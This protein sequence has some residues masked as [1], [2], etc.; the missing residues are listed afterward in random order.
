MDEKEEQARKVVKSIKVLEGVLKTSPNPTQRA[1][2]KREID[3]LRKMLQEMY[4]DEN[5]EEIEES[6]YDEMTADDDIDENS[7]AGYEYLKDVEI[8]RISPYRDD[9]EINEAGSILKYF[10]DR[11][12]GVISDQHT[13]L[14]FS[15]SGER[16]TLYRM[17]DQCDRAFK[18]FSQTIDDID[19]TKSSEHINQLQLMRVKQGRIF[20]LTLYDFF[21]KARQFVSNLVS[22]AEFGGTM[23]L[24]PDEQ[25]VYAGYEE[26]KTFEN[27]EVV[28]S[29]KYMKNFFDDVLQVIKVPDV[30][31]F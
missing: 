23:I 17:L 26:N 6:I 29:L 19:R 3:R 15:N 8:E 24:N 30:D 9:A 10:Q 12:W 27:W 7:F 18:L 28:E 5:I 21:K 25:V 22:D 20:L 13:K 31:K 11:I 4:P 14:D 16:D 2:V 1:R